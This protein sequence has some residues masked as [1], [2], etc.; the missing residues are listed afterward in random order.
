MRYTA[1]MGYVIA[2]LLF[3][4][5]IAIG[6]ALEISNP[7]VE[8]PT[9]L[10]QKFSSVRIGSTTIAAEVAD[11]PEARTTG[12]SGHAPLL[13]GQGMLF[14][15]D[16]EGEWGI[17]MKDMLFSIDIVWADAKGMVVSVA[18]SVAPETYPEIFY[19]TKPAKYVLELP[20]GF[21]KKHR[22]AEGAHLEI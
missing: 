9:E 8:A 17:W 5:V 13:E 4:G 22:I 10:T 12:L 19:P 20:A 11:T 18:H 14:I 3:V 15:F 16:W 6:V 21:A 1:G 2:I 7:R